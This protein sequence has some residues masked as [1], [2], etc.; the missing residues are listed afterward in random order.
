VTDSLGAGCRTGTVQPGWIE[1]HQVCISEAITCHQ[2]C[3]VG[4]GDVSAQGEGL[5]K[6]SFILDLPASAAPRSTVFIR[7]LGPFSAK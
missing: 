2:R 1:V 5:Q 3:V 4:R 7:L 6:H